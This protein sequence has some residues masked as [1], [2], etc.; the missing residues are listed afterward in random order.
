MASLKLT[1]VGSV[2]VGA[3][4]IGGCSPGPD[5]PE[6]TVFS[7]ATGFR[8][9]AHYTTIDIVDVGVPTL[10]SITAHAGPAVGIVAGDLT[11]RCRKAYAS[12]PVSGTDTSPHP[13]ARQGDKPQFDGCP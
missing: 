2:L 3:V 1:A 4:A 11:K 5:G 6:H 12:Y 8:Q 9:P 13:A 10:H 7:V